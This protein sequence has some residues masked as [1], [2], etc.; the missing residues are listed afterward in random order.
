MLFFST[1]PS[2]VNGSSSF[3]ALF[4]MASSFS[5][6]VPLPSRVLCISD[7]KLPMFPATFSST[8]PTGRRTSTS[9]P[10]ALAPVFASVVIAVRGTFT[11]AKMPLKVCFRFAALSSVM[12]SF[13]VITSSPSAMECI[14]SPLVGGNISVKASWTEPV[15]FPMASMMFHRLLKRCSRPGTSVHPSAY[16]SRSRLPSATASLSFRKAS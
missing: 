5:L 16:C 12:M 13:L 7:T 15:T 3:L 8:A 10:K 1:S 2:V 9:T 11:T 6:N 14:C 4:A